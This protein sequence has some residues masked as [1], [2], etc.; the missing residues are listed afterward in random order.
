MQIV[1]IEP[2]A[3]GGSL[4]ETLDVPFP[5]SYDDEFG[6]TF[7]LTRAFDAN[8]VV[9]Q[10]P[11]GVVQ[12]WHPPPRRQLVV[13]LAGMLEVETTGGEVRSWGPGE[14]VL[15]DDVASKGHR[16]RAV[17]GPLTLMYLRL[18]EAFQLED[19]IRH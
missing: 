13:V 7:R 12:D 10:I 19:W 6:H 2:T 3:D 16:S 4:F 11:A 1:R 17:G 5:D 8:C 18:P 9:V 15:A 14:I